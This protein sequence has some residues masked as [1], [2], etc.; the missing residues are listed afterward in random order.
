M[1]RHPE[2]FQVVHKCFELNITNNSTEQSCSIR[3]GGGTGFGFGRQ[4]EE[5]NMVSSS[6]TINVQL[7]YNGTH[8]C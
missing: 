4:V 7:Y 2:S 3:S 8:T 1:N 5:Q 6:R